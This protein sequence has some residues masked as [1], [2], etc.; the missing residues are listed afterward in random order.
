MS[1][2]NLKNTHVTKASFLPINGEEAIKKTTRKSIHRYILSG[3]D[4]NFKIIV[5]SKQKILCLI[6]S[7]AGRNGHF[8]KIWPN[9]PIFKISE[10]RCLQKVNI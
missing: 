8:L 7:L 10:K 9:K 2:K 1:T 4:D 5:T 6:Y 3:D